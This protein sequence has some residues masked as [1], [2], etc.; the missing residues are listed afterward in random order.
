M[1]KNSLKSQFPRWILIKNFDFVFLSIYT[2]ICWCECC[3]LC[4]SNCFLG[5]K[6]IFIKLLL[7]EISIPLVAWQFSLGLLALNPRRHRGIPPQGVCFFPGRLTLLV[8][9]G[10][11]S[12]KPHGMASKLRSSMTEPSLCLLVL[13]HLHC[14]PGLSR[15][16]VLCAFSC[17]SVHSASD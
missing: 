13:L 11:C 3:F 12:T 7:W 8:S 1:L 16:H 14:V 17:H 2:N 6:P 15:G 5:I 9:L 10:L 4:G